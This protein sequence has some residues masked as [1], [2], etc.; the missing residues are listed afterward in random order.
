M[1]ERLGKKLC[2]GTELGVCQDKPEL[3]VVVLLGVD[4]GTV[5][6]N[7]GRLKQRKGVLTYEINCFHNFDQG[8]RSLSA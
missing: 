8:S 4:Y 1:E 6:G 5:N 3:L 7:V 2:K